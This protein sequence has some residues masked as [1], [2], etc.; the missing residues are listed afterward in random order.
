VGPAPV[1]IQSDGSRLAS[2]AVSASARAS[3]PVHLGM[4]LGGFLADLLSSSS[5]EERKGS[6]GEGLGVH[7]DRWSSGWLVLELE[8]LGEGIFYTSG[9]SLGPKSSVVEHHFEFAKATNCRLSVRDVNISLMKSTARR[10][11]TENRS[12]DIMKSR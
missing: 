10:D 7:L 12:V 9:P 6:E 11:A 8:M 3:L 1:R 4:S 2:A 5:S